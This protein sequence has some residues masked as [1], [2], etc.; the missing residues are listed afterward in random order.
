MDIELLQS[1]EGL[2]AAMEDTKL[3][4]SDQ[5]E[6]LC[7]RIANHFGFPYTSLWWWEHL[8]KDAKAFS[9][10]GT[11]GL[12]QLL[13]MLPDASMPALMFATDDE[14]A[15]WPCVSGSCDSL[16]RIIREQRFFEYFIVDP[17]L[18]WIVFDT[19]HNVLI[20]FGDGLRGDVQQNFPV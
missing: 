2:A 12:D 18:K 5:A 10:N 1:L 13:E 4:M 11:E 17:Q 7:L 15:P 6:Q 20:A 16:V 8:P 19:H 9:Y 14:P 3:L